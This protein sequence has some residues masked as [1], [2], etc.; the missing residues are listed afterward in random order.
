MRKTILFIFSVLVATSLSISS[1]V[2]AA[3][4]C[5]D[6]SS[7]CE[8]ISKEDLQNVLKD[9]L[10]DT[11]I[12]EAKPAQVKGL[13]EVIIESKAGQKGILYIDCSK[14]YVVSGSIIDINSKVNLTQ[15]KF[16]EINKA[17]VSKIPLDDALVLGNKKAKHKVIVLDDPE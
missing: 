14:K 15:E 8:Q 6:S 4:T 2:Y 1:N 5:D 9:S 13:T 3:E 10:P 12:L 7:K 16:N 11:K 17:D